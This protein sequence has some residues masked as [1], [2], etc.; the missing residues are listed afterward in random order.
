MEARKLHV[1]AKPM[2][3]TYSFEMPGK[4]SGNMAFH[5]HHFHFSKMCIFC[6]Y[7]EHDYPPSPLI[8]TKQQ[9]SHATHSCT[10]IEALYAQSHDRVDYIVVVLLQ[11]LDSLLPGNACLGH[12]QLDVFVLETG[13]I[14][15]LSVI[16]IVVFLVIALVDS[17]A[18]SAV[19]GVVVARV[20]V[21]GVIVLVLS[22][23]LLG[24]GSLSLRVEILDLGLSED[25]VAVD[26]N[27]RI[28][29]R[30]KRGGLHV[31]VAGRGLVDFWAV[32]DEEDLDGERT[33]DTSTSN[34]ILYFP[35][36]R[37]RVRIS[38]VRQ[39]E[40]V[41]LIAEPSS[42]LEVLNAGY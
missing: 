3:V 36:I 15:L 26:V 34:I 21:S 33:L 12:H 11:C 38:S 40:V 27:A 2:Q 17:L 20:V 42:S 28:S 1:K 23:K 18:L 9:T 37:Q 16:L 6:V 14:N 22:G 19:M 32:D 29:R 25:T 31:C 7:T 10:A 39:T 35:I 13:S 24:C 4:E 41:V 30:V 8:C 5:W